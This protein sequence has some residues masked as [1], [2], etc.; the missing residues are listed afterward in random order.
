MT[1]SDAPRD[2]QDAPEK[3]APRTIVEEVEVELTALVDR[4]KELIRE[5]NVRTVRIKDPKGKYLFEV[6]LTVGMLAGGIFA[7]AAPTAAAIASI[8]GF[9]TR[10]T[11]EIVREEDEVA[12]AEADDDEDAADE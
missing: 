1:E 8:A 3:E 5:G 12:D 6:P 2:D 9:V 11:I 4:I 10:V 7:L